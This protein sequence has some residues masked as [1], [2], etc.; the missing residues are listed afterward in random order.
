LHNFDL[1][2]RRWQRL[3]NPGD[4]LIAQVKN[5]RSAI[6]VRGLEPLEPWAVMSDDDDFVARIPGTPVV[7]SGTLL[8]HEQLVIIQ[9]F[10]GR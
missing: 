6:E 8:L 7:V 9:K 1:A 3:D 2:L 4:A 10:E 5:W